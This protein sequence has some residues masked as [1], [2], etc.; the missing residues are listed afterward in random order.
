[1]P[2]VAGWPSCAD[3]GIKDSSG[4]LAFFM[5]LIARGADGAAGF[6]F[7]RFGDDLVP[8]ISVGADGGVHAISGVIPRADA[9]ALRLGL[10]GPRDEAMR[11]QYRVLELHDALGRA[12][13]FPKVF[14]QRSSCGASAWAAAASRKPNRSRSIARAW[15]G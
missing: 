8:A 12:A 3:R 10:L 2:T 5:R 4:D 11:L 13:D 9:Q 14:A 6:A 1:M 15:S 7:H